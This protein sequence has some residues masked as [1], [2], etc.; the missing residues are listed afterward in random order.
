MANGIGTYVFES[1]ALPLLLASLA[2]LIVALDSESRLW[3]VHAAAAGALLAVGLASWHFS[4]FHLAA[5]FIALA[6]TGWR[7]RADQACLGRLRACVGVLAACAAGA[8]LLCAPLRE[9]AFIFSPVMILG[10]GLFL[11][12]AF[13]RRALPLAL[14]AA[15]ALGL[16]SYL[17]RELSAYGHV[18]GLLWEKL[19]HGLVEP[20]DPALLSPDARLLW[21][22]P[23]KSPE[24]GFAFFAFFPMGLIILPRL[25]S[26]LSGKGKSQPEPGK[27]GDPMAAAALI[28]AMLVLYLFG[29]AMVA[30]LTAVLAFLLCAAA[31]RLP[32]RRLGAAG[33]SL[34]FFALAALEG[35]KSLSPASRYNPFMRI[36]AAWT[37]TGTD[38]RPVGTVSDDLAL[39]RWLRKN[40]GPSRPVLA[41]YGISASLLA[42]SGC[43]IL[44]HP[45]FEAAGIRAKTREF[46]QALYSTEED[47][48][49]FCRRYEAALFVYSV[50]DI[51]D[52]SP[53]GPRYTSGD[54]RLRSDA[55]AVLFHF[56]PE[57]LKDFRLLYEN[58]RYR[59][60]STS[61]QAGA[62]AAV[63]SSDP[64]YDIARFS[65][66]TEAGGRLSLDAAGVNER[67]AQARRDVLLAHILVR[68]DRG[69]DALAAYEASFAAWPP[70]EQVRQEALRLRAALR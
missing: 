33:L 23:F 14:A 63:K 48:S 1:F 68:M 34:L 46:L 65:P 28:D 45:K 16:S 9:T 60:F 67:M 30:R 22:G 70:D 69:E 8:G 55:A 17:S 3:R 25:V 4:R 18:Y 32:Q 15:A 19:R 43:P 10:Y 66:R 37:G 51:L 62:A 52:E 39:I 42:Y 59:V 12:L 35:A 27:A 54:L 5:L 64:V 20:A 36:A 56:H 11:A 13:P 24:P 53:D 31:C 26:A 6:W 40:G 44:L 21:V 49:A 7:C 58:H 2:F 29:T 57:R 38:R 61:P 47:F 50:D 41:N